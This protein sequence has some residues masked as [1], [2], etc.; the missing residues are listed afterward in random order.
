M[1]VLSLCSLSLSLC[2]TKGYIIYRL[3]DRQDRQD[4][5]HTRTGIIHR[6]RGSARLSY[7]CAYYL[8]VDIERA[9]LRQPSG[10]ADRGDAVELGRQLA[11]LAEPGNNLVF[12]AGSDL[13]GGNGHGRGRRKRKKK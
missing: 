12:C 4:D 3:A 1:H 11:I 5:G 10:D 7:L 8:E 13:L 6:W 9:D 2:S